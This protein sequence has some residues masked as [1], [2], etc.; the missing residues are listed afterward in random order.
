M[1]TT[2][3]P[4]HEQIA[5]K[6]IAQLKEGTSPFQKPW[7]DDASATFALP[8]NPTTGKA[9][10][11][12]NALWLQM[13]N[14]QDPRWMTLKQASFQDWTVEKGAKATLINFVKTTDRVPLTDEKGENVLDA[15]GKKQYEDVKLD[16]PVIT[17]AWVFNGEQIKGIPEWKA[18]R[19]EA[20][21][22][23]QFTPI[24]RGEQ[25]LAASKATINHGGNEAWYSKFKD[26][27][28]LPEKEQFISNTKYY[29]TALHELGHWTGHETRLD[30][31]MQGKFGSEGYAREELRAEIA[32]LMIGGELNIGHNFGNHAA[33]VDNWIKVLQDDPAELQKAAFEAQ[34]IYDYVMEFEQK[35]DLKQEVG[36]KPAET[37]M[38]NE[39]IFYKQTEYKVLDAFKN[40]K[41]KMEDLS[42]GNK[43][44]IDKTD[45]IY[46]SL[47]HAKNNPA[48]L[49]EA[50]VQDAEQHHEQEQERSAGPKR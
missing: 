11:G 46:G 8:A 47:M 34:N 41:F 45:T 50:N 26:A 28:Q 33:Y 24:E 21:T 12:L 7:T 36:E 3:K 19:A 30:R 10:R 5:D 42:S 38:K 49:Q 6:L 40:G 39:T 2:F 18:V 37:L 25:I 27:I 22:N 43:F 4:L 23:Q 29:A 31:P 17:P 44:T 13:Q 48:A 1:S 9:Y 15:N 20:Q 14:H 32:S 35:L 16:K